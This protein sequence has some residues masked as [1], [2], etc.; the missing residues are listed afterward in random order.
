MLCFKGDFNLHD[1]LRLF[2][3]GYSDKIIKSVSAPCIC[4]VIEQ[5]L[6]DFKKDENDLQIINQMI[7]RYSKRKNDKI[8]LGE[9]LSGMILPKDNNSLTQLVLSRPQFYIEIP[10]SSLLSSLHKGQIGIFCQE[11]QTLFKKCL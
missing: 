6:V 7:R 4:G 10:N 3:A 11:T 2:S 5:L 8:S 1:L 9:F